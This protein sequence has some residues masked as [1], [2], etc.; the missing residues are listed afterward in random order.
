MNYHSLFQR[1]VDASGEQFL[2][3]RSLQVSLDALC[4]YPQDVAPW[5]STLFTIEEQDYLADYLLTFLGNGE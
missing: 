5:L 2:T 3:A 4:D 1:Y